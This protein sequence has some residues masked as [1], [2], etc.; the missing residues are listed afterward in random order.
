MLYA[1]TSAQP[2][3]I[4]GSTGPVL[5]FV[6]TLYN[7]SEKLGLPF[8]PVYA[9]TGLWTSAIL[10][11]SSITSA[12]SLVKYLTRY[13]DEIFSCLISTIFIV[14]S[15]SYVSN[16]FTSPAVPFVNALLTLVCAATTYGLSSILKGVRNKAYGSK[17]V[18]I[19]IFCFNQFF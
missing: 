1:L 9:W 2:L 16:T 5:A 3:T 11:L 4:I 8:L 7:F 10:F 15:V 14:D 19:K 18:S 17:L 12:S 13:T 6:A